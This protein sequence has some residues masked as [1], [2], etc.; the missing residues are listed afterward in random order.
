M[1]AARE[2]TTSGAR[3]MPIPQ[4]ATQVDRVLRAAARAEATPQDRAVLET[5][6][7]LQEA[8]RG[9]PAGDADSRR[10]VARRFNTAAREAF[11]NRR[12]AA[13]ALA[14][15]QKAFDAN[16]LDPEIAGNLAFYHLKVSPPQP[17]SARRVALHA[18]AAAAP[19]AGTRRVED[20]G[21]LAV[22]SALTERPQDAANALYVMLAVSKDLDRTCRSALSMVAS[23]G[24]RLKPPVEAMF[25]RIN[26]RGQARGAPYC[27][28]PPRWS[29]GQQYP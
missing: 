18:L 19:Q 22:A 10:S 27:A 26:A 17:E 1:Q 4:A 5:I 29:A 24:P 16:P 6:E 28:W 8:S 20:W 9:R 25:A 11:W 15:Q 21:N 3:L 2:A 14:L 23:Y 13:E 7:S 12:D